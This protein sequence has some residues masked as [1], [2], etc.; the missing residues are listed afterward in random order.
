MLV[1]ASLLLRI[2]LVACVVVNPHCVRLCS[3]AEIEQGLHMP[4]DVPL[5]VQRHLARQ[6]ARAH[7][8]ETLATPTTVLVTAGVQLRDIRKRYC[9]LVQPQWLA[10]AGVIHDDLGRVTDF[11]L[12]NPYHAA[13]EQM[14]PIVF[15][16]QLSALV[17]TQ[18]SASERE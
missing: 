13:V 1:H 4:S 7:A 10:K 14:S 12:K 17:P 2:I 18:L 11:T 8:G 9:E 16:R 15:D 6:W 3:A 5:D